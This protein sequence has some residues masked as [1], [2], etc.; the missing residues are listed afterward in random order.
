MMIHYLFIFVLFV[1]HV[2]VGCRFA[3]SL[4]GVVVVSTASLLSV[5]VISGNALGGLGVLRASEWTKAVL[6]LSLVLSLIAWRK[7][8]A[9]VVPRL[10]Y[11]GHLVTLLMALVLSLIAMTA[12]KSFVSEPANADDLEYHYPKVFHFIE[13]AS[14]EQTGL[15]LVDGYPQNGELV[16]TFAYYTL[17]SIGLIDGLQL[18]LLPLF[19][20][21]IWIITQ[22]L[23]VSRR[24]AGVSAILGCCLPAIWSLIPTMHVDFLAVSLLVAAVA[25][26]FS[27]ES[28]DELSRRVLFGA[29]LGLLAGTK[30]V[31]LPWVV[32]LLVATR[33]SLLRLRTL[34]DTLCVGVPIL[35]LG[36][37]RYLANALLWGNPLYPYTIPFLGLV[38]HRHPRLLGTL[39]EE[40]MTFGMPYLEKLRSSWFSL[41][42]IA[43]S[44]HE[45]WFGGFGV[46]WLILLVGFLCALVV[47]VRRGEWRVATLGALAFALFVVTPAN[48]TTRFVLFLPAFAAVGFG[49]FLEALQGKRCDL[50]RY[51][52][53]SLS[54]LAALHCSRQSIALFVSEVGPRRGATIY[55][56]CANVALPK[57]LARLMR[58]QVREVFKKVESVKVFI[59]ELPDERMISYACLWQLAPHLKPRFY[60][61]SALDRVAEAL[62]MGE[63]LLVISSK[64]PVALPAAL[65]EGTVLFD[66]DGLQVFRV[67]RSM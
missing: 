28:F 32:V 45:H 36:G 12:V 14:F 43:Q 24:I 33:V 59:G 27:V 62:P 29:L 20:V 16:A 26:L 63:S 9:L 61:M 6:C 58:S 30:F 17:N 50:V 40:R 10:A 21:S 19:C 51:V 66:G 47:S 18:L 48:Y 41:T 5:I 4:A 37:E 35:L 1:S 60:D 3:S 67:E 54:V 22:S 65:S 8:S 13:S 56:S 49:W 34:G 7:G 57:G 46:I 11:P 52:A 55:D 42:S 2:Y 53:S 38:T 39:W 64:A 15:E 44:N 23:G 25:I 31:A